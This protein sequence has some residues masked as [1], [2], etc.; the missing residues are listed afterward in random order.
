MFFEC[1]LVCLS[2]RD[3][4][5]AAALGMR[6]LMSHVMSTTSERGTVS[7]DRWYTMVLMFILETDSEKHRILVFAIGQGRKRKLLSIVVEVEL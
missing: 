4:Y 2:A 3:C 5:T 1:Y 7:T 6:A